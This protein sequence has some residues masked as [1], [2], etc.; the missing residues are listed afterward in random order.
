MDGAPLSRYRDSRW[1]VGRRRWDLGRHFETSCAHKRHTRGRTQRAA[2][3]PRAVSARRGNCAGGGTAGPIPSRSP[4]TIE[5]VSALLRSAAPPTVL[6]ACEFSGALISALAAQG[7]NAISCDLR[8]AEHSF[9]HYQGDVRDIVHLQRWERAYFFPNCFQHLR[10][11]EHCLRHKI[12]DCRAF[13]AAAMVLWCLACPHADIVV[14]EQPD[15][16]V[17]HRV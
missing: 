4:L 17:L 5:Q 3:R 8:P 13:W 10:G 12:H 6:V 1:H 14:V 9:P 2:A 7:H 15:T 16:I 11:D